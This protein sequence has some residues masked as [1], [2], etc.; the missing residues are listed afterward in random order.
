MSN[1]RTDLPFGVHSVVIGWV[2]RT[3]PDVPREVHLKPEV[4]DIS[5]GFFPH[6][7]TPALGQKLN[8]DPRAPLTNIFVP[9]WSIRPEPGLT[10]EPLVPFPS[11]PLKPC[12]AQC[13]KAGHYYTLLPLKGSIWFFY[14]AAIINIL[15]LVMRF[16]DNIA[17]C[18]SRAPNE[19]VTF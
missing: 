4:P 13:P 1:P 7:Q 14:T 16:C 18:S 9:S 12:S 11:P 19:A 15:N 8:F 3:I 6:H 10:V 17:N 5:L 2:G